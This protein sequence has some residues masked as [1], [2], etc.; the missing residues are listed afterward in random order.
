VTIRAL[1]P[2]AVHRGGVAVPLAEWQ[3]KKARDLVMILVTRRGHAATREALIETLWPAQDPSRTSN[4]LSVALS[5]ARSVLDREHRF[6]PGH[7]I[8]ADKCTVTLDLEHVSVDVE[9]FLAV[10]REGLALYRAGPF[11][12]AIERLRAAEA[13]YAGDFLEE[14]LYEDWA[15]SLRE[16]ARAV[17]FD[18]AILLAQR[19]DTDGDHREARRL[20]LGVIDRDPYDERPHRILI[21]SLTAAGR[22]GDARGAYQRYAARMGEIG[23]APA[24]WLSRGKPRFP[25]H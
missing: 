14:D 12:Q 1:G 9:W 20:L 18:V 15:V 24:P 22:H 4:R 3:S 6:G 19:A 7:Y 16:E 11:E 17:Y 25:D 23:V 21:A 10:A 5:T 2:F 13:A 8:R